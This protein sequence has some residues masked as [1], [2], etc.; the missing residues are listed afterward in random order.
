ML[1]L[2]QLEEFVSNMFCELRFLEQPGYFDGS[3]GFTSL[4]RR[5][6]YASGRFK[7][8]SDQIAHLKAI[9]VEK[10]ADNSKD[11]E[12]VKKICKKY[13]KVKDRLERVVNTLEQMS[14]LEREKEK[15]AMLMNAKKESEHELKL[16]AQREFD[17]QRIKEMKKKRQ[18][19]KRAKEKEMEKRNEEEKPGLGKLLNSGKGLEKLESF[20]LESLDDKFALTSSV[21]NR[22]SL[23]NL[24]ESYSLFKLYQHILHNN[25]LTKSIKVTEIFLK[26]LSQIV[27]R[28]DDEK[29][30]ILRASNARFQE[31]VVKV[32]GSLPCLLKIGF[33]DVVCEQSALIGSRY[34]SEQKKELWYVMK[35]PSPID[36]VYGWSNWMEN[37]QQNIVFFKKML[38]ELKSGY[39]ENKTNDD[40]M[41]MSCSFSQNKYRG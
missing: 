16:R 27:K 31:S 19:A 23:R 32:K 13:D 26:L 22:Q 1:S 38:D 39:I 17:Y 24:A 29:I 36:D 28:P 41:G 30:R 10:A 8:I 2:D 6:K 9:P 33:T 11:N 4:Y 3:E 15:S 18:A 35:V 21:F 14:F 37:I 20:K 34:S 12:R 40:P 7:D 5:A 25:E